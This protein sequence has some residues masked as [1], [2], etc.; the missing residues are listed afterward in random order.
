MFNSLGIEMKK[1]QQ[2]RSAS[3]F[4]LGGLCVL[5]VSISRRQGFV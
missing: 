1:I 3:I 5:G 2:A 4:F